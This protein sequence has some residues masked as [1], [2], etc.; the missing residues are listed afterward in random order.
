MKALR[1]D[2][3]RQIKN[4]LNRFIS[5]LLIVALGVA[6]YTG[7]RSSE[8]D[9]RISAD[10]VYDECN[11]MDL[12]IV[13]EIG[14]TKEDVWA[15]SAVKGVEMAEGSYSVDAVAKCK[16]DD[17][18][19]HFM[20]YSSKVN[21][22]RIVSGK[23]PEDDSQC[24]IDADF[25][26]EYGVK[27]GDVITVE[28]KNIIGQK[29]QVV[30]FFTLGNYLTNNK[31][32]STVG[33]GNINLNVI[34]NDSQFDMDCYTDIY[35]TVKGAKELDSYS[36]EYDN[37]V[38]QVLERIEDEIAEEREKIRYNE[39]VEE[40][41][42]ELESAQSALDEKKEDY[43]EGIKK[44][45]KAENKIEKQ[46]KKIKAAEQQISDNELKLKKADAEY[47]DGFQKYSKAK[48][49]YD[50]SEK[51]YHIGNSEYLKALKQYKDGVAEY[52]KGKKE[53]E[54]S[55]KQYREGLEA[56]E[57]AKNNYDTMVPV[58]GK[59]SLAPLK[60]E[61]DKNKIALE[62]AEIKI[63]VAKKTLKK[64]NSKLNSA[65]NKLNKT[66]NKLDRAEKRLSDGKKQLE[67]THSKLISAEKEID[68]GYEELN[69]AKYQVSEGKSKLEKAKTKVSNSKKRLSKA[70]KK[71]KKAQKKIDKNR[72]KLEEVE[73]GEWYV[74]DRKYIQSY[75]EYDQDATRIGNIGTV[76]PVIF[77]LVAAMVSL[78]TMTRMVEEERVQI[79]TLKALGYGKLHV[80]GKY[81]A[82][83][84]LATITGGIAGGVLG[85]KGIPYVIISAYKILYKNMYVMA[86]PLNKIYYITAVLSAFVSV[87]GATVLACYAAF[88]AQPADL[89]RPAAPKAGKRVFLERI[90]FIWR[91]IDFNKKSTFRNL[92][93]Y[94]K[95]LIMTLFGIS[96]CMALLLVGFG[97]KHSINSILTLQFDEIFQYDATV[98]YDEDYIRENGTKEAVQLFDSN[99]KIIGHM[100][101]SQSVR[102][103]GNGSKTLSAYI[104]V[105]ETTEKI[106]DYIDM[107][108]RV[109]EEKYNLNDDG[110]IITEK[111]A[112]ELGV[113]AGDEIYIK[114]SEA[115]HLPVKVSAIMEN[116][117]YHY[118]Y[119]TRSTYKK[120]YGTE[121]SMNAAFLMMSQK[122]AIDNELG[123]K[124]IENEC[125]SKV[126]FVGTTYD[127]FKQM[128]Q[129]MDSIVYVLV[130]SAGALAFIVLY[131]LNNI[132]IAERR[133]ELATLKV[134]G[135]YDKEVAEYIYRENVIITIMG[136]GLGMIFGYFLHQYVIQASEIDMFMFGR[137]IGML[138]YILGILV[139]NLFAVLIN[140]TMYYKLKKVDM[141]TSLKSGE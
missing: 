33:T 77:F 88:R 47:K 8:S 104:I 124:L 132:N 12:R 116:Y 61:L 135:F 84:A 26:E 36:D 16:G 74:L 100:Q 76:F 57:K 120:L 85:G 99:E 78:T 79:G 28:N 91:R 86:L 139:T 113:S 48:A 62:Q 122:H 6:F 42:R 136:I 44:L 17:L 72:R 93:R 117:C 111:L 19:A 38:E 49:E 105:P 9:M 65:K 29:Y 55:E 45:K 22:P 109:A 13:S 10:R 129:G 63:S 20:S 110:V 25:A 43:A 51:A 97:L 53:L 103:V 37:L 133:R 126:S 59:D 118:L 83:G 58:L 70:E 81:L 121:C 30:G 95:R 71:I 56:Y 102:D 31:G 141:A 1:K 34:L 4:T 119:M 15:V 127:R 80:A 24:I 96:G 32:S 14:V 7:I 41:K 40:P 128:I 138:G 46:S 68:K 18:T 54:G 108:S 66:K 5:L 64:N 3:Y 115:E 101:I 75:V 60:S 140:M 92:F 114:E 130:I 39:V 11:M 90:P 87:V 69:R 50:K 35:V 67:S 137:K 89:M 125:I 106:A 73:K 27:T 94:K 23:M 2:F 123:E 82:Y 98:T 21:V 107:R 131:N 134:L 52:N 112:K